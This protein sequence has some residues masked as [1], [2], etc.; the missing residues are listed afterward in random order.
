MRIGKSFQ[1]AL[2]ILLHSKLRSWLTIIGII[3]GIGAVV[4]IVSI[5]QGAE[6]Q[7]QNSLGNLGADILT[8]SPGFSQARGFGGGFRD[9]GEG[10]QIT[11]STSS[12]SKNL[13]S[14]DILVLKTIDNVKYVMGTVSGREDLTYSSKTSTVSITGVDPNIWKDITTDVAESGRLLTVGDSYSIVIGGNLASSTFKDNPIPLNGKVTINGK[15]FTV[16]GILESGNGVYMPISAARATIDDVGLNEF[17]SILVKIEDVSLA[18]D[19][20][21]LIEK[22]LMFSRGILTE[23]Q[24]DFSVN[25][26]SAMQATM[27]ETMNTM[28]LFLGAIAAISLLVGAIGI[29]NTMFTSVLEKTKEIGIMKAIGAKNKDILTIFL[30]NSGMIGLVGGIGGVILGSFGSSL[31]SYW[32]SSSTTGGGLSRMFSSTA[33]TPELIFGALFFSVLI[34]MIAGVIPAYRASKLNPVDALRYE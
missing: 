12:T 4:S 25:N 27:Q 13:T 15:T 17:D 33:L 34:G 3:I 11:S 14:R 18:D 6:E 32:G 28:S 22:K 19:T 8:V 20:V 29:A 10:P 31:I 30:L 26:P 23:K 1:L 7:L 2:N 21:A 24:K 16:V 9:G 5:S